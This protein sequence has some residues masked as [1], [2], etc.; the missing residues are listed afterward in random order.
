MKTGSDHLEMTNPT[1]NSKYTLEHYIPLSKQ[2]I[3]T[4]HDKTMHIALIANF[5]LRSPLPTATF[6]LLSLQI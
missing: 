2:H 1:R 4:F 6:E 5:E 3:V